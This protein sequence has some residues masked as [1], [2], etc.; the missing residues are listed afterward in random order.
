MPLLLGLAA[1]EQPPP[2]KLHGII[3]QLQGAVEA[4]GPG[5]SDLPLA[6]PW[7]VIRV[8]VTVR[9]PKGGSAGIVCSTHRFVRLRGPAAWSLTETACSA[10]KELTPAEYS[11]VAPQGGRFKVVE[12]LLVLEREMRSGDNSDP[13]A[14]V[15]LR[16]RNTVLRSPR[17]RVTWTR[18]ASA[19]EYA[20]K[21][22][23]RGTNGL[24]ARLLAGDVACAED[25][26]GIT[27]CSLP[28]PEDRPDLHPGEI[29]FL[30]I[31]ARSGIAEPWHSND[32]VEVRSQKTAEAAV[33]EHQLRALES[34]GLQG[35]ALEA[36]RGGLLAEHG[37]YT[38]AAELYRQALTSESTPELRIT[39]ADLDV[40]MG[41]FFR[42]EP[43]YREALAEGAPSIRAAAAFGLGRVAY[44]R[45]NY[46]DAATFFRQALELYSQLGLTE[47]ENAT[48][49]AA[50]K[51]AARFPQ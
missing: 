30:T 18:V 13:L 25:R 27:L 21:W 20:V 32:P 34:L 17:P 26:E 1:V 31:A 29:F 43:R 49:L 9:V 11:L 40:M 48:R 37:L 42:A 35:A 19:T 41:L 50:E 28:W 44:A 23:G 3:T 4:V 6:S 14:P 15:V 2:E 5:V 10:G 38:D 45:S 16:P 36:A 8:G 7:Q 22:S 12:G 51:A 33:L 24:D 39:V 47:E 46:R